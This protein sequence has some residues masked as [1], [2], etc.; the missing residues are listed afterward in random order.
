MFSI[1]KEIKLTNIIQNNIKNYHY[2]TF[3]RQLLGEQKYLH[4]KELIDLYDPIVSKIKFYSLIH[5]KNMKYK[6]F[7][8]LC[9]IITFEMIADFYT[10]HNE[11]WVDKTQ[12]NNIK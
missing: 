6:E 1:I 2:N 7:S 3:Y 4:S 11:A 9:K 12:F 5:F 10:I 8:I